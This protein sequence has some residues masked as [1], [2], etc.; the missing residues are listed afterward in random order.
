ML[1]ATV[2][3]D[4]QPAGTS[5][6]HLAKKIPLGG[7]G[8]WDY[9][10]VDPNTHHVLITRATRVMVV[11]PGQGKLV[12]E[13]PKTPF[14]HGIAVAPELARG[15]TT[16]GDRSAVTIFDSNT[17]QKVGEA[18]TGK[19]PDAILYDPSSKRVFAMNR[20]GTST[21]INAMS[22]KVEATIVLGGQPEFGV[23]DGKGHVFVNLEN[24]SALVDID[25]RSLKVQHTWPLAP[26]TEPS[27]LA[28]DAEHERLVVGCHNKIM[29][30]V[31]A[32]NGKV[33]GTVP[34]GEGV[35]AN[36]FDPGTGFAFASCGDGTLTVA[37]EDSPDKFTLVETVRTQQGARTMAL[38]YATHTVYLVTAKFGPRPAPTAENPRPFPTVLPD[39]FT[40]LVFAR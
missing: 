11:D 33:V 36:R 1:A 22:G 26:C 8:L 24:N 12:G 7:D 25:S 34:I 15:F 32:T 37:H 29:A 21:V 17:F 39:S 2:R 18:K 10:E 19:E 14:V 35:D 30:F 40:L 5:G 20:T 38:D 27:G 13:V 31:D 16:D 6:Y 23:A 4:P 9:L 3:G 28:I